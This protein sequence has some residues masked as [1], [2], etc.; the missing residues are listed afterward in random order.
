MKYIILIASLLSLQSFAHTGMLVGDSQSVGPFGRKLHALLAKTYAM[1]SFASCGSIAK[2]WTGDVRT[3]TTCG[4][5]QKKLNESSIDLKSSPTPSL[6][7]LLSDIKPSFVVMEFA[8]NY[9]HQSEAF[10][11]K[12]IQKMIDQVLQ[13]GAQCF[14]VTGPDT[15]KERDLL[16]KILPIIENQVGSQCG[17]FLSTTV[18]RYPET[19]GDGFHYSFAA[20]KPIAEKWAIEVHKALEKYLIKS[21]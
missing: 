12:D 3:K 7:H 14:F 17:F 9:R 11:R 8:G 5:W 2:W 20:G 16:L 6:N 19:G 18:T 4:Y 21:L 13:S 10:I 1:S 15:R